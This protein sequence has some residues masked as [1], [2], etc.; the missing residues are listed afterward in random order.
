MLVRPDAVA[1]R[2][3]QIGHDRQVTEPELRAAEPLAITE[4]ARQPFVKPARLVRR[5]R[6]QC[7]GALAFGALE[8]I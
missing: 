5:A 3:V 1:T 2:A 6:L 8:T 4:P 7:A